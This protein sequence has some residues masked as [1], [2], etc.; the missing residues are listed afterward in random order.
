MWPGC[1]FGGRSRLGLN[2]FIGQRLSNHL[3]K[4]EIDIVP[5]DILAAGEFDQRFATHIDRFDLARMTLKALELRQ[6]FVDDNKLVGIFLL[7][8]PDML[9][10]HGQGFPGG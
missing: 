3:Q 6:M 1:G 9:K 2:R 7:Q 5:A 4:V 10:D 8:F